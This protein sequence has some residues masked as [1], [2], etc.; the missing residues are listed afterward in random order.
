MNRWAQFL[1]S[2][3][4]RGGNIAILL[5]ATGGL[6]GACV[7]L[8]HHG[9]KSEVATVILSTFSGFSGALLNALVSG[10]RSAVQLDLKGEPIPTPKQVSNLKEGQ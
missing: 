6:F 9:D 8:L 4:S 1:D 10:G 7:H 5:L 2:L 3:A